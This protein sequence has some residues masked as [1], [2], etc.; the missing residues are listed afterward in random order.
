MRIELEWVAFKLGNSQKESCRNS[1]ALIIDL[2][3]F[4]NLSFS[5]GR[6]FCLNSA[7]I[8]GEVMTTHRNVLHLYLRSITQTAHSFVLKVR[9]VPDF[10]NLPNL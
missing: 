8:T 6:S 3:P 1:N 2:Q 9:A 10:A 5:N 7:D 4:E